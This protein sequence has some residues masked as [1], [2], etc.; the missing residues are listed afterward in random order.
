MFELYAHRA[1][2]INLLINLV[3]LT[4]AAATRL[5]FIGASALAVHQFEIAAMIVSGLLA[6]W[7]GAGALSRIPKL[8]MTVIFAVLLRSEKVHA[9][10][11]SPRNRLR[12]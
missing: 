11:A 5:N 6:A 10:R 12:R 2:R 8:H 3:T 7:I 9:R 4:F 1:V